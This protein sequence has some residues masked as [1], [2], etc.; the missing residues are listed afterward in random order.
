MVSRYGPDYAADQLPQRVLAGP[1]L[2]A[3]AWTGHGRQRLFPC[4]RLATECFA[5]R[6][7][8]AGVEA[9]LACHEGA[10]EGAIRLQGHRHHG[11]ALVWAGQITPYRSPG[12]YRH[13]VLIDRTYAVG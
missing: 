13:V 11:F 12:P 5:V 6:P 2:S 1:G 10:L 8:P 7:H 9:Y 3:A 4:E